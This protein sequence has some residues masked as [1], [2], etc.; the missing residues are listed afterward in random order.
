MHKLRPGSMIRRKVGEICGR[1]QESNHANTI[2]LRRSRR[3][4]AG[5]GFTAPR[6]RFC[7]L[8]TDGTDGRPIGPIKPDEKELF[9]RL[10]IAGTSLD[11]NAG[12]K[13]AEFEV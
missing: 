2:S 8:A 1:S 7:L 13:H 9:N 3:R 12:T 6:T 11:A 5:R 10:I 4:Q